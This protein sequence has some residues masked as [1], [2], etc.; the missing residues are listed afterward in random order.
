MAE[1]AGNKGQ[2][3]N[4]TEVEKRILQMLSVHYSGG[5]KKRQDGR[6]DKLERGIL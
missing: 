3:G 5:E 6:I 1:T 2:P 4:P